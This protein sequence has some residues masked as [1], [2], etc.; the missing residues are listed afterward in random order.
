MDEPAQE[1]PGLHLDDRLLPGL[2]QDDAA[3]VLPAGSVLGSRQGQWSLYDVTMVQP[4]VWA[5][6]TEFPGR[7]ALMASSQASIS[8]GHASAQAMRRAWPP[9]G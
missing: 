4:W 2:H 9:R 7:T 6:H 1:V 5:R 3:L 8:P